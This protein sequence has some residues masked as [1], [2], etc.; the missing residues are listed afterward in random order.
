MLP[1]VPHKLSVWKN[2]K[3]NCDFDWFEKYFALFDFPKMSQK[4]NY[5]Q[6]TR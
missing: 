1:K 4:V 5:W 3:K 2:E 6:K